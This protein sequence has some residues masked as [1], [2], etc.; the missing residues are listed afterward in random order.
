MTSCW[1]TGQP[2]LF[3]S[4]MTS[5]F[6]AQF[7]QDAASTDPVAALAT[8]MAS[9]PYVWERAGEVDV[10]DATHANALVRQ[11]VNTQEDF[12]R[13]QFELED[14]VWLWNGAG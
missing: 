12:V 6:R 13:Y 11:A 2:E 4:L 10:V 5:S 14:G 7:L 3:L 9:T 1:A 8:L